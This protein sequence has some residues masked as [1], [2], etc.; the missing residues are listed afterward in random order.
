MASVSVHEGISISYQD[1]GDKQAP[2]I[3][4]IMGLGAQMTLWPDELFY[5]LVQAGFRVVRFDNRDAGLSTQLEQ[6]GQPSLIKTWLSSRLPIRTSVPY[7]LEEMALDTLAL[8]KALKIKRAHLVG[9]SMG[10]MIA[11]L[12]AAKQKKKVLSLTSIMSSSSSLKLTHSNFKVF[13]KLAGMRPDKANRDAAINYNIRLN[14]LIGSPGYPQDEL[15]LKRQAIETVDRAYNPHGFQRQLA[16]MAASGSRQNLMSKVKA[17][18]LVIHGA[19]DPIIPSQ[20][21]EKTARQIRKSKLKIVPGMG[22][23]FPPE[24][25]P[26]LIKWIAKHVRKSEAKRAKK[27]AQKAQKPDWGKKP[28]T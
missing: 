2:A 26:K 6:H 1:E 12:I 4:L 5:G 21:G 8:M 23:N 19:A 9:A 27:L 17:P 28:L 18:T 13:I 20:E 11:Q 22:H 15:T 3:V 24:L 7:T 10:G 16:A 25:T 14:Q